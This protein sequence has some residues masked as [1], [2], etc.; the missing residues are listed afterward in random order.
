M[1]EYLIPVIIGSI[2]T[3]VILLIIQMVINNF[4]THDR[5]KRKYLS[6][7]LCY[8]KDCNFYTNT[9]LCLLD[10]KVVSPLDVE[11]PRFS[12]EE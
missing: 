2:L 7:S 4:E 10:R 9:S 3:F 8:C 12:S 5:R 11:C 1:N 6:R